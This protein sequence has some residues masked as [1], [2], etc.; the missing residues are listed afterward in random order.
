MRNNKFSRNMSLKSNTE[1]ESIIENKQNY[2]DDALQAVIW[3]L[4]DRGII[5]KDSLEILEVK[6]I[7]ENINTDVKLEENS[8]IE[9]AFDEFEKP[10]LYSKKA[11]QGFTIFFSTIFGT[12]LLMSNLKAMNKPKERT[13]VLLFGIVYTVFTY[14]FLNYLP[15]SFFVTLI[16]NFIGYG[17]L[18]EYY[19]NKT[20]GKDVFHKKKQITKP[21][22]IS[23]LITVFLVFLILSPLILKG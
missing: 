21:L 23:L 15:K 16:F 8:N 13:Q 20:L 4:E 14:F 17:V 11:I 9:N 7:L 19:W 10:V 6:P 22:I 2:T 1:L 5:E 12:A 3:E 18:A